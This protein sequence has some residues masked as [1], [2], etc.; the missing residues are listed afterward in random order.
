M[1]IKRALSDLTAFSLIGVP[2]GFAY[3]W[4]ISSMLQLPAFAELPVT[5]TKPKPLAAPTSSRAQSTKTVARTYQIPE[6]WRR[7]WTRR[8]YQKRVED[9]LRAQEMRDSTR[10]MWN[11]R[12]PQ[13][14]AYR[15]AYYISHRDLLANPT[16]KTNTNTK[17]QQGRI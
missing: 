15:R 14:M 16:S 7:E 2:L 8:Q 6:W 3:A 5:P 17:S 9:R 12:S 1:T 10:A 11:P 13:A 4:L